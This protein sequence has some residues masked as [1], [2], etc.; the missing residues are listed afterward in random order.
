MPTAV[1]CAGPAVIES[2]DSTIL[3]PSAW[4]AAMDDNGFVLLTRR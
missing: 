4:Q 2:V 3:V 1:V